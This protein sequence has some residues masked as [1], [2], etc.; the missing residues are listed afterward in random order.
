MTRTGIIFQSASAIASLNSVSGYSDKFFLDYTTNF[1]SSFAEDGAL[2][3]NSSDEV[4][5]FGD[6]SIGSGAVIEPDGDYFDISVITDLHEEAGILRIEVT[7]TA[8]DDYVDFGS[9]GR[10]DFSAT[11]E[12]EALEVNWTPGDDVFVAPTFNDSQGKLYAG[13]ATD[14]YMGLVRA[15]HDIDIYDDILLSDFPSY[16]AELAAIGEVRYNGLTFEYG[17][18]E[19]VSVT[20]NTSAMIYPD[21]SY[22]AQFF[23]FDAVSGS[24]ANDVFIG[25]DGSQNFRSIGGNDLMTGGNGKDTFRI[26]KLNTG[27][28]IRTSMIGLGQLKVASLACQKSA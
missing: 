13:D 6:I 8:N 1:Y 17:S 11:V 24:F 27:A 7:G 19:N 15:Q 14:W 16:R 9:L 28:A 22:D 4:V 18:A 26:E 12:H 10:N 3:I 20:N 23:N 25:T 5:N 21:Y 2:L